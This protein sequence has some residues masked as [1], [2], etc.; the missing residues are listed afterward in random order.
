MNNK[1]LGYTKTKYQAN[2]P[3]KPLLLHKGEMVLTQ[4]SITLRGSSE[5][6]LM[7]LPQPHLSFKANFGDE[8]SL[9]I[10]RLVMKED[11]SIQ[12]P[13]LDQNLTAR[14]MLTNHIR[15]GWKVMGVQ[16]QLPAMEPVVFGS[17]DNIKELTLHLTNFWRGI[18]GPIV[19]KADNWMCEVKEVEPFYKFPDELQSIEGYAITHVCHLSKIDKTN[20]D[21]DEIETM[22]E[23][24]HYF[25][26]FIRG[27][28]C[29]VS[30][31]NGFDASGKSVWG[32]WGQP[33]VSKC[34]GV[35][36]WF[37]FRPTPPDLDN[38]L[39]TFL[40]LWSDETCRRAMITAV[41][42]YINANTQNDV[43]TSLLLAQI[44][45]ETVSYIRN[46]ILDSKMTKKEFRDKK[47]HEV[48]RLLLD[49]AKIPYDMSN[50]SYHQLAIYG[51][52]NGIEKKEI[53]HEINDGKVIHP[54]D[55]VE[56]ITQMRNSIV[57]PDKHDQVLRAVPDERID[58]RELA[59][60]YLE[61]SLLFLFGFEERYEN[62]MT[63]LEEATPWSNY[64]GTLNF[65]EYLKTELSKLTLEGLDSC[66]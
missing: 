39:N 6:K 29:G 13:N 41:S 33:N 52:Q 16:G 42:L 46:V 57:H 50:S 20:F 54:I 26:S 55:G 62:R 32:F 5:I 37:T 58:I 28:W 17:K 21:S 40:N 27:F 34:T 36:S 2:K 11:V 10:K 47:A 8:H 43:D 60:Q 63:N 45:L 18:T 51:H 48:I 59:L 49:D 22:I 56:I 35:K 53:T 15:D 14:G 30:Q 25:F 7:W 66:S 31:I 12:L 1:K 64:D 23:A 65:M 38:M 3:N 9:D 44:G 24:L 4:N 19:I 61:L